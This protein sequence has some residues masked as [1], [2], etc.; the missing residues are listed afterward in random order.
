MRPTATELRSLGISHSS[1]V[2]A[3]PPARP[4]PLLLS[5]SHPLDLGARRPD[6]MLHGLATDVKIVFVSS[7]LPRRCGIATF[8]ADLMAAVKAADPRVVCRVAAIDEP[9]ERRRYGGEVRWR[10][11]QGDASNYRAA[12]EAI[13]RSSADIVNVQHEF[14]LYG[15]WT[16]GVYED[17]LR[18]FLEALRK[19]VFT[20][21]HSV[22]PEPT[23][24]MREAIRSAA[25]LSDAIVVMADA[26]AGILAERYG[27]AEVPVVIPHGMPVIQP[28]GRG[29]MK[30]KLGVPDRTIISTFGLVDPRKG[31]EYM[32][33]AMPAIVAGHPAALYVIAGQTHPELRRHDGEKYRNQLVATVKR[34]GLENHV[35]FI[36]EYMA[37]QD[38]IELLLASD[39]YVTPYLDPQQITSGTL[40]YA[41]GAG[42]AI[43]STAYLH[44]KEALA[45][46]RGILVPFRDP[47]ALAEAVKSLLAQ[48]DRMQTLERASSAYARDMSWPPTGEHWLA[49]M[50]LLALSS[51][52]KSGQPG[53][54]WSRTNCGMGSWRARPG[55]GLTGATQPAPPRFS[56]L[57]VASPTGSTMRHHQS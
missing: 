30:K 19:P 13:N 40:A 51:P 4:R 18:P 45:D 1:R 11:R 53:L 37:Q 16:D 2:A 29:R 10:I 35:S 17:H 43:V 23:L 28:H 46:G 48:P 55:A 6:V 44:A 5:D 24:S 21:L 14:G 38:I 32:I 33:E 15:T 49:L 34:L 20:T 7:N 3:A 31:I 8:S 9:N 12:A 50:R 42:K 36:D 25:E 52:A 27:I 56:E 22:P 39:V 41:L 47:A 26:A 57:S 54:P